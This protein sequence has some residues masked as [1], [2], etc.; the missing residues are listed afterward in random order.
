LRGEVLNVLDR[1]ADAVVAQRDL[2]VESARVGEL[3]VVGIVR[4]S[5]ELAY[6]VQQRAGH[7]HV[8]VD[9]CEG[10]AYRADRLGYSQAMLKQAVSMATAIVP[11]RSSQPVVG[12]E[13]RALGE[14]PLQQE[15]QVRLS[16]RVEKLADF[17]FHLLDLTGWTVVQIRGLEAAGLGHLETAQI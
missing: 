3:D 8:T 15:L 9:A 16:N 17:S 10:G 14:D 13:L 11:A 12:T 2:A 1:P 4:V 5:L 7:R 6:V